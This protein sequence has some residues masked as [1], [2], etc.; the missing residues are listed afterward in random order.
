[1][2]GRVAG[3]HRKSSSR[4]LT[5]EVEQTVDMYEPGIVFVEPKHGGTIRPGPF[6]RSC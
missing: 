6:D 4:H 5:Y 2:P 1:M 3:L